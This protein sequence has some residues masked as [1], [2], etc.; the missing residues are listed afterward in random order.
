MVCVKQSND[1]A[2]TNAL[3]SGSEP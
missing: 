1:N 2:I 3:N